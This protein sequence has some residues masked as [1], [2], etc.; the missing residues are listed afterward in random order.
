[1][2]L[3][4]DRL[5]ER[6]AVILGQ[7][8]ASVSEYVRT[9]NEAGALRRREADE[10]H[11]QQD[12]AI[13]VLKAVQIHAAVTAEAHSKL[14]GR[15]ANEWLG[16]VE[17]GLR[18]IAVEQAVIAARTSVTQIDSRLNELNAVVR[19]SVIKVG[20]IAERNERI[21]RSLAWKTVGMT[22]VWLIAAAVCVRILFF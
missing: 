20:E 11:R 6:T 17:R 5:E 12:E 15:L 7:I 10:A 4:A 16:L 21:A 1:M 13:K 19:D 3:D 2:T 22:A 8:Q 9:M 14:A 18:E